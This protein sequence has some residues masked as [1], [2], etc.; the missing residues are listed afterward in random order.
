[1]MTKTVEIRRMEEK[2]TGEVLAMMQ[3]FYAS[4]A[5]LHKASEEIL[6]QDI[7]DCISDMPF[8]E[9]YVFDS[10]GKIAGY[11]MTANSYSTEFGGR[12]IWIEDLYIKPEFRGLGL[13]T[14]FFRFLEDKYAGVAVRFRLEAEKENARAIALYQKCGYEVLPYVQLTKES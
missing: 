5:V 9:G 4:P 14:A 12:C 10:M 1:M 2:D 6:R 7:A 8:V 3:V 13:G 11:A